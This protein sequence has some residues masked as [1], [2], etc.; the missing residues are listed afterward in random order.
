MQ[1]TIQ[2]TDV[3]STAEWANTPDM[4]EVHMPVE[5]ILKAEEALRY[6]HKSGA[7]IV[8]FDAFLAYELYSKVTDTGDD[9]L[10]GKELVTGKDGAKYVVAEVDY[11]LDGC[12]ARIDSAGDIY[13]V[14]PFSHTSD[15][16]TMKV[17]SIN[18]LKNDSGAEG[19]F[20]VYSKH[21]VI[22]C[23][24][25]LATAEQNEIVKMAL[26]DFA[27]LFKS[28]DLQRYSFENIANGIEVNHCDE[29]S[30]EVVRVLREVHQNQVE[31]C[32]YCLNA[33]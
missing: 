13:A 5:F 4:L 29:K 31:A 21:G 22:G 32:A 16:M 23:S 10:A 17:G 7:S 1:I 15:V 3:S 12:N 14:L 20:P 33:L 6:M 27:Y 11:T 9:D 8:Q 18:G 30:N 26:A 24:E 19:L 25:F 28:V 2:G